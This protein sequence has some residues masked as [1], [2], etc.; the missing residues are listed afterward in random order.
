MEFIQRKFV[1]FK[2]GREILLLKYCVETM[3]I[4]LHRKR[5]A[6]LS[7][8]KNQEIL[9]YIFITLIISVTMQKTNCTVVP[10]Y[11]WPLAYIYNQT[12]PV[13]P[14]MVVHG[15]VK[16]SD[17]AGLSFDGE[18][19]WIDAGDFSGKY[20]HLFNMPLLYCPAIKR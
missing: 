11:I 9:K 16:Q 19:G 7:C 8:F 18:T 1:C 10:A 14:P 5:I 15:G 4:M 13:T 6:R 2:S 20:K 3:C 12:V 17:E